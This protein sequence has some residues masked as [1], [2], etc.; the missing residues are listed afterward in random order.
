M[1]LVSRVTEEMGI[2][3][4]N[5]STGR[6]ITALVRPPRSLFVNHPMGN[7]FGKPGDTAMQ[8]TILRAALDLVVTATEPGVLVDWPEPWHEDFEYYAGDTSPEAIARQM[9][10]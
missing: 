1:G 6:D 10:K 2:P 5:V 7:T 3:T 8:T 4:V 9:K